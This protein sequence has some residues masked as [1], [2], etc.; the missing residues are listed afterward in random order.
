MTPSNDAD[1]LGLLEE[2]LPKC[3]GVLTIADTA[4]IAGVGVDAARELLG[5]L[6]DLYR[7]EA[8]ID[9]EGNVRV[10]FTL[11]L[12]SHSSYS[13][14]RLGS[15][16]RNEAARQ[17]RLFLKNLLRSIAESYRHT[18]T[19]EKIESALPPDFYRY[20]RW[21]TKADLVARAVSMWHGRTHLDAQGKI[22]YEFPRIA[23]EIALTG[24]GKRPGRTR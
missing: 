7:A 19:D 10:R 1:R 13:F 9:H 4:A 3:G 2:A 20:V 21:D 18:L 16:R 11:P 6:I 8:G 23:R 5:R 15:V 22:C 24:R 17:P 12:L 14:I